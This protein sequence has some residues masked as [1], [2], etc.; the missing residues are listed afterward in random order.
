M[1]KSLKKRKN[2]AAVALGGWLV[3]FGLAEAIQLN[4]IFR[5]QILGAIAIVAG[6]LVLLDR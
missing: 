3:V 1:W 5:D 2:L 6:T 4:F